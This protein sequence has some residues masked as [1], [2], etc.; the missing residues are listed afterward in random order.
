MTMFYCDAFRDHSFDA[1]IKY[2]SSIDGEFKLFLDDDDL[3]EYVKAENGV[4]TVSISKEKIEEK[5]WQHS[6]L[7]KFGIF[8]EEFEQSVSTV[9]MNIWDSHSEYVVV[10]DNVA[11]FVGDNTLQYSANNLV[12]YQI[13]DWD[14]PNTEIIPITVDEVQIVN[15]ET[16]PDSVFAE[17]TEDGKI[18]ISAK[19]VAHAKVNLF[20]KPIGGDLD[21]EKRCS[22]FDVFA[23]EEIMSCEIESSLQ[24]RSAIPGS[25]FTLK[26]N[27][28]SQIIDYDGSTYNFETEH[29]LKFEWDFLNKDSYLVDYIE[30]SDTDKQICSVKISDVASFGEFD[31][32]CQISLKV[33]YLNE[34]GI[35]VPI[36]DE[37]YVYNMSVTDKLIYVNPN[38]PE[39]IDVGDSITFTPIIMQK[40]KDG[41][42]PYDGGMYYWVN[43]YSPDNKVVDVKDNYDG[44]Y[45]I[46]RK[47][48]ESFCL[49][50]SLDVTMQ[51]YPT[52][53]YFDAIDNNITFVD[54]EYKYNG[55]DDV[56]VCLDKSGLYKYDDIKLYLQKGSEK[57]MIDSSDYLLVDSDNATYITFSSD[58][59]KNN[60]SDAISIIAEATKD[61]KSVASCETSIVAQKF[62]VINLPDIKT[63][64]NKTVM[65]NANGKATL[66][67]NSFIYYLDSVSSSNSDVLRVEY[68][69]GWQYTGVNTGDAQLTLNYHYYDAN[70][71]VDASQLINVSVVASADSEEIEESDIKVDSY[72]NVSIIE[73]NVIG[74]NV[75]WN[76]DNKEKDFSN[77]FVKVTYDEDTYDVKYIPIYVGVEGYDY[78]STINVNSGEITK[79]INVQLISESG[80]VLNEFTTSVEEYANQIIDSDNPEY[81]QYKN[82]VKAMLNYGA[83]SQNYF[84]VNTD[85]LA[86]R[87]LSEE[88]KN[89]D[90]IPDKMINKYTENKTINLDGIQYVGS[91][92][93]LASTTKIRHYFTIDE[94]RDISNYKFMSI[95]KDGSVA[96]LPHKADEKYYVEIDTVGNSFFE[97]TLLQVKSGWNSSRL[98]YSPMNYIAKF[99]G[100]GKV[101]DKLKELVDAQYWFNYTIY[102]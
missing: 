50:I 31:N 40:T 28:T 59:I 68:D 95:N 12:N 30:L 66:D 74:L 37:N 11:F 92:L 22:S 77:C 88:D 101:D 15:D 78:Y 65:L 100:S 39:N 60:M 10:P 2:D 63:S 9:Q 51:S 96:L 54:T 57:T 72:Q 61:A 35:Y 69:N 93:V 16:T 5:Y 21:L 62:A 7:L 81:E 19:Q 17:L 98:Y 26:A 84:G 52:N 6:C 86:N 87:S 42:S 18:N 102:Q 48:P 56:K 25:E 71:R 13:C 76:F 94:D 44:T 75:Y 85:K 33:S 64:L 38:L 73:S 49:T 79:R 53:F 90:V 43:V 97:K 36:S 27:V 3:S 67:N 45:I 47:T 8:S 34:D 91:S 32:Y 24:E 80:N 83:A 89:I 58:W 82:V 46:T 99:Y 23:K 41:D 20:Y 70:E 4:A 55:K 1:T 29:P 14:H